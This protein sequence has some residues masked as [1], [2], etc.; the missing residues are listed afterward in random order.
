MI[1][2]RCGI[3]DLF[4][5]HL[6]VLIINFQGFKRIRYTNHLCN[7]ERKAGGYE[8]GTLYVTKYVFS[9]SYV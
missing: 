5:K 1:L 6:H 9:C 2:R 3:D 7:N 4:Y 8:F